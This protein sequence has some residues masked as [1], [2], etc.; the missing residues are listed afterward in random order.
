[1]LKTLQFII[2]L[3]F[4]FFAHVAYSQKDTLLVLPSNNIIDGTIIKPYT[5]KWKVTLIKPNGEKVPN[6][7]W[8][9]YGQIIDLGDKKYFHRVQ[10]L[11]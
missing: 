5:N 2:S 1:M 4:L 7:I 3:H 9:D 6:K 11:Y 8:T 10:N